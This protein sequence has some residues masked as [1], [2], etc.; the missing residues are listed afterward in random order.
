MAQVKFV[1]LL[2]ALVLLA[3]VAGGCSRSDTKARLQRRGQAMRA[4]AYRFYN[5]GLLLPARNALSDATRITDGEPLDY[6]IFGDIAC[7]CGEYLQAG[8]FWREAARRGVDGVAGRLAAL[9]EGKRAV[10]MPE[11]ERIALS[12]GHWRRYARRKPMMFYEIAADGP[13]KWIGQL[14]RDAGPDAERRPE[15]V[16]PPPERPL[17]SPDTLGVTLPCNI[18]P[19]NFDVFTRQPGPVRCVYRAKDGDELAADGPEIRFDAAAWRA[20][21]TRHRGEAVDVR[22]S[23]GG[24]VLTQAV[25]AVSATPVD[26]YLDYRLIWPGYELWGDMSIRRRDLESFG[27]RILVKCGEGTCVN[28][29]LNCGGDAATGHH[30][31]RGDG[32]ETIV[33]S[34]KHGDW[35]GAIRHPDGSRAGVYGAWHPS[36]DW[37]AFT[38]N[39]ARQFFWFADYRKIEVGDY[40]GRPFLFSVA[41]RKS[42]PIDPIPGA[43]ESFPAWSA[44]GRSLMTVAAVPKDP[45]PP[46]DAPEAER[47]TWLGNGLPQMRFSLYVREFDARTGRFSA[48]AM[49]FD[50]PQAGLSVAHPCASPDGRWLVLTVAAWG[51]FPIWHHEADLAL[52]DLATRS[53]RPIDELNS[54]QAESWHAFSSDGRWMVFSSRRDDGGFTRPYIAAF[55]PETGRFARPFRLPVE[56]PL[57]DDRRFESYNLPVFVK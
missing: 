12:H 29:H 57:A 25:S 46:R 13:A 18:A 48:P 9:E 24:T 49:V 31:F 15:D 17:L 6:V 2:A 53:V 7:I 56:S 1:R 4:G 47:A 50:G 43:L 34:A 45:I 36:G 26:R 23:A 8:K 32:D 20:F 35:R 51:E 11:L 40:S 41:E 54:P 30:I 38:A 44:D 33:R 37:I 5:S 3:G 19:L 14:E 27:E 28:C 42:L 39:E 52:V 10:E 16:P 21:L 55:D 22:V